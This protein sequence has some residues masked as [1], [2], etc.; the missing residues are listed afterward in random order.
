MLLRNSTRSLQDDCAPFVAQ[1][2]CSFVLCHAPFHCASPSGNLSSS[3]VASCWTIGVGL[4][5]RPGSW[6]SSTTPCGPGNGFLVTCCVALASFT[7]SGGCRLLALSMSS[8][9]ESPDAYAPAVLYQ[10]YFSIWKSFIIVSCVFC[11]KKRR[12]M[13]QC[14]S[15]FWHVNLSAHITKTNLEA[16]L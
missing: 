13:S 11:Q 12:L 9:R 14:P 3:T 6:Q 5:L 8:I 2:Y 16:M 4:A 1:W 10:W 15:E 7:T